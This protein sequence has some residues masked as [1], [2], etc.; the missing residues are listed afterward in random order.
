MTNTRKLA[1]IAIL[2]AISFLLLFLNFPILPVASFLKIDFSVIPILL[3]LLLFDLKSAYVV[4]LLRTLLKFILNFEGVNTWVGMP[5]NVVALGLFVT[6]FAFVWKK[7]QTLINYIVASVIA[8]VVLTLA[9]L[10]LNLFY[11]IPLYVKFAGWPPEA[12]T[13]SSYIVPAVLPFNLLQGLILS[14]VFYPAYLGTKNVLKR[15]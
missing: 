10:V 5:M 6:V 9:M 14:L 11:A 3:A 2:S 4:L 8:T 12:L 7:R 1:Y 13:M 15:Y